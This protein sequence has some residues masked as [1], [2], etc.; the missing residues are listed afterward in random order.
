MHSLL[1]LKPSHHVHRRRPVPRTVPSDRLDP[2]LRQGTETQIS[3]RHKFKP[4]QPALSSFTGEGRCPELSR[5]IVWTLPFGRAP[6]L[7]CHS[8]HNIIPQIPPVGIHPLNPLEL[9]LPVPVLHPQFGSP[10]F[11]N[12]V[13]T[14]VPNQQLASVFPGEPV[15]QTFA[16]FINPFGQIACRSDIDGAVSSTCHDIDETG[17]HY[18]VPRRGA[19][20]RTVVRDRLGPALRQGKICLDFPAKLKPS[21]SASH[22]ASCPARSAK[23]KPGYRPLPWPRSCLPRR[24]DHRTQ[25]PRHGPCGVPEAP[26][27]RR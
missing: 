21:P 26:S 27:G 19:G 22:P 16:M 12:I 11:L 8:L 18:L 3:L 24:P 5:P 23:A 6:N 25:S 7:N 14:L 9:P 10:C 13:I 4:H 1:N 15:D 20:P 17:F 2:A